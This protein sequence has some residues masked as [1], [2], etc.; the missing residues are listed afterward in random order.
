MGAFHSDLSPVDGG[1]TYD[2]LEKRLAREKRAR[3][4][5]EKLLEEKG[6]HLQMANKALEK[7][8]E[9]LE[10]QRQQLNTILDHTFAAIFLVNESMKVVQSNRAA[11]DMF[12]LS[13]DDLLDLSVLDLF[14]RSSAVG[15]LVAR[16]L[17]KESDEVRLESDAKRLNGEVFPVEFGVTP[18]DR[19]DGRRWTVWIVGDITR[20]RHDEARRIALER[21]LSQAQ[22]LEALGTLASG[23]A[24]EINTPIQYVGDNMRFIRTSLTDIADLLL[25]YRDKAPGEEIDAKWE[26]ADIDFLLEEIP[27]A[28]EQSLSGLGQVAQIVKAIKEFSH[29]G[30]D[31]RE[32]VDLNAA[33][34]TTLTVSRNQW[35]YVADI[36]LDLADDLPP[37]P[38][39]PGDI[40]QVLLNMIV[41]AAD[42]I[43]E[44]KGATGPGRIGVRTWEKDGWISIQISDTGCGMS[45]EVMERMFDPFF[46]TKDVGKGSGQG[47][48]ISY[49]IIRTK[50]KGEIQ[51]E[52]EVGRGTVFTLRLPV[53]PDAVP[54]LEDMS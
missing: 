25:M 16:F 47:L 42:A 12:G 11:N 8:A 29:P 26:A 40:N 45:P 33:I 7:V 43:S 49:N 46:T 4:A 23:V 24:H 10:G 18:I 20:R 28:A 54:S 14:E 48:A 27:E 52:S 17:R 3:L 2:M 1:L 53:S 30:G 44:V 39:S 19:S 21:D 50:H 9:N 5:A 41:N 36:D 35:K 6:R 38:C 51:C 31:D 22:K 37:A 34:E 15:R 32:A 13:A